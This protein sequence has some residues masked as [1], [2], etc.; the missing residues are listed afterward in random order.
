MADASSN[1]AAPGADLSKPGIDL[2]REAR[3][4]W[5]ITAIL[6][7]DAIPSIVILAV[8]DLLDRAI[9]FLGAPGGATIHLILQYSHLMILGIYLVYAIIHVTVIFKDR[10]KGK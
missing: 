3:F 2:K 9:S 5:N 10:L 8:L 7:L 4:T 6:I 1:P